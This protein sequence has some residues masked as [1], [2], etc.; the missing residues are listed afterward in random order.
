MTKQTV[1]GGLLF[2]TSGAWPYWNSLPTFIPRT[3]S[4]S[5]QAEVGGA[6]DSFAPQAAAAA[7]V[8]AVE[9]S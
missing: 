1:M 4:A 3:R 8:R 2:Y 9:G 5:G 7:V 6:I